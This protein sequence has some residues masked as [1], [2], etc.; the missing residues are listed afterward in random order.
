[1][2]SARKAEEAAK[3]KILALLEESNLGFYWK[4]A[5]IRLLGRWADDRVVKA[6]LIQQLS[7]DHPMIRESAATALGP[8]VDRETDV[9]LAIEKLLNDPSR[10]VRVAAAHDLGSRVDPNSTA[11]KDYIA[12]LRYQADQPSG[13]FQLALYY[14]AY[15]DV[16]AATEHLKKAVEWDSTSASMRR[17]AAVLFGRLGIPDDALAQIKE[18]CRLDPANAEYAFLHGLAAVEAGNAAEGMTAMEDAVRLDP[19]NARAWYNLGLMQ[20]RVGKSDSALNAFKN[21]EAADANDAQIPYA[22][23]VLL[24][25][26]NR[27]AEARAAAERA[28]Q[29]SP[30]YRD[31]MELL[32]SL[33]Q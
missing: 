1:V 15:S 28:L 17:E 13:Q 19:K 11:G 22:R 20:Q 23:A 16:A 33:P 8:L 21:G 4:S 26:L 12:C 29:I 18:A 6:E 7:G 30:G 14:S 9:R 25:Q 10:N 5:F 27:P 24:S 32:G 31:A 3:P 2:A